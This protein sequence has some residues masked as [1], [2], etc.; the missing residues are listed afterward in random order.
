M[1]EVG[2]KKIASKNLSTTIE[3][4]L[5]D[6]ENM[7]WG[8]LLWRNYCCLVYVILTLEK[9]CWNLESFETKWRICNPRNFCPRQNTL[10][11]QFYS[12]NILPIIGKI[13]KDTVAYGYLSESAAA[14]P[15]RSFKQYFKKIGFID[16]VAFKLCVATIYFCLKNNIEDFSINMKN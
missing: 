3:M 12:K 8:Q 7:P 6:S 16:V 9:V 5:G 4:I 13:F 11:K 10:Q 2:V 1:L 14:F 15:W